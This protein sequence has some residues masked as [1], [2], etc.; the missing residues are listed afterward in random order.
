MYTN[1]YIYI[2]ICIYIHI[3]VGPPVGHEPA[4]ENASLTV[5]SMPMSY[6][7]VFIVFHAIYINII[8]KNTRKSIFCRPSYILKIR[9][10]IISS[11]PYIISTQY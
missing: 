6:S 10:Y 1:I 9:Y 2:Y 3:S 11:S 5:P 4:K 7:L 8:N